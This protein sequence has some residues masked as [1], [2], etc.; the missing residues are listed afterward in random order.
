MI[1]GNWREMCLKTAA[2][3][4]VFVS[5]R[6]ALNQRLKL[7]STAGAGSPDRGGAHHHGRDRWWCEHSR[8][9]A[10]VGRCV[11][12]DRRR[13]LRPLTDATHQR[14]LRAT[15][16]PRPLRAGSRRSSWDRPADCPNP[17]ETLEK[18]PA[19]SHR[20]RVLSA[21]FGSP[22][23][24]PTVSVLGGAGWKCPHHPKGG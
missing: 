15:L 13:S 9:R 14:G 17:R 12:L 21:P 10:G 7:G 16:C 11:D 6:L 5:E 8:Q 22:N 19:A 18:W 20:S 1:E 23:P 3:Q 4:G 24:N 2:H